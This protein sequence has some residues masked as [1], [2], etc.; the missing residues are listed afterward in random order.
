MSVIT[1]RD[2]TAI[3]ARDVGNVQVAADLNK[4]ILSTLSSTIDTY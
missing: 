1:Q 3:R 2:G 4:L